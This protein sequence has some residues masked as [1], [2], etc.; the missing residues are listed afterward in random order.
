MFAIALGVSLWLSALSVEFRDVR[1]VVP[2]LVQLW[3]LASPVA[4]DLSKVQRE[5]EAVLGLNPMTAALELFRWATHRHRRSARL[6][7]SRS[8]A[9]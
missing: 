3:L 4:Y 6:R 8:P 7:S 5:V 9:R 1:Y 2:L